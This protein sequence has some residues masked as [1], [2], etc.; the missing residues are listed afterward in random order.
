MNITEEQNKIKE[1]YNRALQGEYYK[2]DEPKE[3]QQAESLTGK[4]KGGIDYEFTGIIPNRK[5]IYKYHPIKE[6]ELYTKVYN[7]LSDLAIKFPKL[8]TI[9][10]EKDGPDVYGFGIYTISTDLYYNWFKNIDQKIKVYEFDISK[11]I[12]NDNMNLPF[13]PDDYYQFCFMSNVYIDKF[14]ELYIT[15]TK[16]NNGNSLFNTLNIVHN[17]YNVRDIEKAYWIVQIYKCILCLKQYLTNI[18]YKEN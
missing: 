11:Q 10:L 4:M 13:I 12:F 8:M 18:N 2:V 1:E 15:V 14:G 5:I 6:K 16:K 9:H 7:E 3:E 17:I